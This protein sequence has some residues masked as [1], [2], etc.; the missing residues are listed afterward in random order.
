MASRHP[1]HFDRRHDEQSLVGSFGLPWT[2]GQGVQCPRCVSVHVHDGRNMMD[3]IILPLFGHSPPGACRSSRQMANFCQGFCQIVASRHIDDHWLAMHWALP[4]QIWL[5]LDPYV[6][7]AWPCCL[8]NCSESPS[9]YLSTRWS[10]VAAN[11]LD[12]TSNGGLV[13]SKR[14]PP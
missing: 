1:T 10:Q 6:E 3:V 2:G 4:V 14:R 12:V 13:A 8:R 9:T 7:S 11:G 5:R